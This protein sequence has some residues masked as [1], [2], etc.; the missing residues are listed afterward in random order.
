MWLP[1][2]AASVE[3]AEFRTR[4]TKLD[5]SNLVHIAIVDDDSSADEGRPIHGFVEQKTIFA[6]ETGYDS[7]DQ[8]HCNLV[9]VHF[10]RIL[11]QQNLQM[12]SA[13]DPE[14]VLRDGRVRINQLLLLLLFPCLSESEEELSVVVMPDLTCSQFQ[15]TL[16]RFFAEEEDT[17][18]D[19]PLENCASYI[20]SDQL[21]QQKVSE[22]FFLLS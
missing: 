3:D 21:D 11:M 2:G 13:Y 18:L 12:S 10:I 17:K 16:A 4:L 8:P 1:F 7:R 22:G 9:H 14:L 6:A 5:G 19:D 15:E 20:D